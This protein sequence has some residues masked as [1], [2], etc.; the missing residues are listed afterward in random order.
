MLSIKTKTVISLSLLL[1]L[2]VLRL[3]EARINY[4]IAVRKV[5]TLW[6]RVEQDAR[7]V[8]T[9]ELDMTYLQLYEHNTLPVS[10][11]QGHIVRGQLL[12]H[13]S[14]KIASLRDQEYIWIPPS[15]HWWFLPTFEEPL[16]K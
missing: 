14:N 5:I 12:T 11:F 1:F 15:F 13:V 16:A 10:E 6:E 3:T 8:P 7:T 9:E 2:E 4:R